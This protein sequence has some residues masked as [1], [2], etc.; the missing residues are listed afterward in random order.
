MKKRLLFL[1]T[2]LLAATLLHAQFY[3]GNGSNLNAASGSNMF[4]VG[5]V[6]FASGSN[7]IL[8][9]TI[10]LNGSLSNNGT[11][12]ASSAS[13]HFKGSAAQVFS[14]NALTIDNLIVEK[15]SGGLTLNAPITINTGVT[16]TNGL[17]HTDVPY[18]L[19][20]ANGASVGIPTD[21]SHVNGPVWYMGTGNFSFPVGNPTYYRK[22]D[23]N[24][25]ANA[26]G[27]SA[28]YTQLTGNSYPPGA[29]IF[30]APL[31]NVSKIEYWDIS[32][33]STATG[34]VTL[35]WDASKID[36]GIAPSGVSALVVGHYNG[37]AWISE[38]GSAT[39]TYNG[40]GSITSLSP[41]SSWSSFALGTTSSLNPLPLNFIGINASFKPDGSRLVAWDVVQNLN[42]K[43]FSI[44]RSA[45]GASFS[46]VGMVAANGGSLPQTY[47]F[48][49]FAPLNEPVVFYRVRANDN[50]G[51]QTYSNIV[52]LRLMDN[53][54]ITLHPNPVKNILLASFG[55]GMKGT[56]KMEIFNSNGAQV[57]DA[58]VSVSDNETITINR[59]KNIVQGIYLI[60]FTRNKD[61]VV[62]R[63]KLVFE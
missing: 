36:P 7:S 9:G 31:N 35:N 26:S 58:I 21:A 14:G 53:S 8:S 40:T 55:K 57:H 61:R 50:D 38:G 45:N 37:S 15:S 28:Y 46:E 23:V 62:E 3:V 47:Q 11:I 43:N 49:D 16:F 4:V 17:I 20:F 12:T 60:R 24:L 10:V 6:T 48:T 25:S 1:Q 2:L 54:S 34:T 18:P 42:V 5:D 19:I 22:V 39:G 52:T 33:V 13:V 41:V 29:T 63:F 44:L 51:Q 59:P 30:N 56:Y 32:P 27:I